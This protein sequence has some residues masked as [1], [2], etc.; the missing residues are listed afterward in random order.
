M[1]NIKVSLLLYQ[2]MKLRSLL[3]KSTMKRQSMPKN[4]REK[5][6]RI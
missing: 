1:L 2:Q 3:L 4:L 5:M 6:L